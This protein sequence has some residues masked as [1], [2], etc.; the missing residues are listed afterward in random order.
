ME[1]QSSEVAIMKHLV[2]P[3]TVACLLFASMPATGQESGCEVVKVLE[4]YGSSRTVVYLDKD[5]PQTKAGLIKCAKASF[6]STKYVYFF[7]DR[8]LAEKWNPTAFGPG[9][10]HKGCI[11]RAYREKSGD[12]VMYTPIKEW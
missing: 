8:A 1:N 12:E 4:K 2:I 6:G 5:H 9:P 3:L 11:G 10:E 7:T